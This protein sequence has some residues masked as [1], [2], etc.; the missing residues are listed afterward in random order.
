MDLRVDR[1]KQHFDPIL[2]EK[3]IASLRVPMKIEILKTY[4]LQYCNEFSGGGVGNGINGIRQL[5]GRKSKKDNI[6]T[7]EMTIRNKRLYLYW[8]GSKRIGIELFMYNDYISQV[9]KNQNT[10]DDKN[11]QQ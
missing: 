11:I 5:H 4:M 9:K 2:I 8:F 1:E 10:K 6:T 3:T 7:T